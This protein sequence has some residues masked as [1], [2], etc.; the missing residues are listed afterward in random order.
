MAINEI[1]V[2][3]ILAHAKVA[4]AAFAGGMV[5]MFLR[6]AKNF[7]QAAM[8]VF[9]CTSCGYFGQPVVSHLAGLPSQ[10][11]GAIGALLGLVGVSL[12]ERALK[13]AD[14][15]DLSRWLPGGGKSLDSE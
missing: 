9:A 11:D 7:S 10:F 8:L 4:M 15:A 2:G 1:M 14:K 12:A 3:A 5:R 6:P 13:W